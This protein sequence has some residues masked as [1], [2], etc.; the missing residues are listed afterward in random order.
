[1]V[2]QDQ[3]MDASLLVMVR[4]KPILLQALVSVLVVLLLALGRIRLALP[5]AVVLE[6]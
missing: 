4:I 3:N 1:M 6:Q 5:Q 2:D